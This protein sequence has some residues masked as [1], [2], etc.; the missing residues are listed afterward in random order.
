M[1]KLTFY[2]GAMSSGKTSDLIQTAYQY[3]SQGLKA[4]IIKPSVDTKG[5][6]KVISR[7]GLE[8]DVDILLKPTESI[9]GYTLVDDAF[10]ILVDEAQ[11]LTERQVLELAYLK[12]KN[13]IAIICYGLK[14]DFRGELFPGSAML[15]RYA[16]S[17][18]ELKA[19]CSCGKIARFNA[20]KVNGKYL[21]KGPQVY[22]GADESYD[23]LCFDC[24]LDKVL[25]PN[26][27]E[28]RDVIKKSETF[29][30]V[31]F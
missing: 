12:K 10:C 1:G 31:Y 18:Q 30:D 25:I 7:I 21:Y 20:R 4:I 17:F 19:I 8:K 27:K 24:Y 29:K 11:F 23:P 2:Y 3:N 9:F 15:L 14:T 6:S 5:E 13:N 28:F 22:I 16:D 26:D